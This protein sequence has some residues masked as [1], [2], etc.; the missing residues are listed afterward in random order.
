MEMTRSFPGMFMRGRGKKRPSVASYVPQ[1]KMKALEVTF[2]LLNKQQDKCPTVDEELVH[3]RA[4][5]GRRTLYL[6]DAISHNEL[7]NCLN[8][9][10]PKLTT[11]TG[12][13]L[14]YKASGGWGSRKLNLAA[15]DDTGYSGKILKNANRGAKCLYIAPV[16]EELCMDPLPF[17]HEAFKEMHKAKCHTCHTDIPIQL[18]KNHIQLCAN[19]PSDELVFSEVEESEVEEVGSMQTCPVCTELFPQD[20]IEDHASSCGER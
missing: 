9:T 8:N 4:G 11:V 5:L 20:I 17:D 7:N 12:G 19:A 13:W 3:V 14:I 15:P 1:R 18:L 10:F 16:Q 2:Y 6:N